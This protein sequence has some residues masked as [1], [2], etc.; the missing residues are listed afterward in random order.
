MPRLNI[1]AEFVD[2][3]NAMRFGKMDAQATVSFRQLSRPVK[4]DDGIEPTEL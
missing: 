1:C 4:Y 2:M 3:L